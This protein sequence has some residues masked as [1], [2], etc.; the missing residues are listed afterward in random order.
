VEGLGVL[1]IQTADVNPKEMQGFSISEWPYPLIALNG[2]DSPRR[3]LFTLLHELCHIAL[4][5]GGVCEPADSQERPQRANEVEVYCNKVAAAI[6]MPK[7]KVLTHPLVQAATARYH[8]TLEELGQLS[9]QFGASSE[10]MLLRLIDLNKA[11]WQIYELRR[12]EFQEQYE[13][14]KRRQEERQQKNKGR[15]NYYTL[16]VRNLGRSY[17]RSV[18]EA[19]RNQAISSRDVADYLRVRFDQLGQLESRVS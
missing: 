19:Y 13:S 4:N 11:D 7:Q 16:K 17:V 2:K 8:W 18:L 6:L 12:R 15:P 10:S 3:R 9:Q 5:V 14:S 1:V